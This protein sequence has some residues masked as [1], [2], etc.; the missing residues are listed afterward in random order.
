MTEIW[1]RFRESIISNPDKAVSD[2]ADEFLR[3]TPPGLNPAVDL[4]ATSGYTEKEEI[5][6]GKKYVV[7]QYFE[8]KNGRVLLGQTIITPK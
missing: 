4:F 2:Y 8:I 7:R 6:G 1:K 5:K 3:N